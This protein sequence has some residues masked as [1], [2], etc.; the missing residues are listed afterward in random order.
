M[1]TVNFLNRQ[2]TELTG[3]VHNH[4][5]YSHDC[6][7]KIEKI[8]IAAKENRLDYF[9]LNDH[10]SVYPETELNKALGSFKNKKGYKPIVILGTELNDPKKQ[11]H[12]LIFDSHFTEERKEIEEYLEEYEKRDSLMFAAHPYEERASNKYPLYIWERTD[13]L[14]RLDGLEIW[15]YASSWLSKL[16]PAT[17]GILMYLFPH[18]FVRKPFPKSIVLWDNLNLKGLRKSAVGSTDAHSTVKRYGFLKLKILTH[19]YLFGT[20]RTNVLLPEGSPVDNSS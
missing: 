8:L 7:V 13:L 18:R 4:T 11:H 5:E 20:V 15:N 9:T 3:A 17:N 16:N 1:T 10:H 2:Y 19:K 12:L 6:D 14:E